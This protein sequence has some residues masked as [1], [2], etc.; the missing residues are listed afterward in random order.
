MYRS[1]IF[2][3]SISAQKV[4]SLKDLKKEILS[5]KTLKNDLRYSFGIISDERRPIFLM[6]LGQE[7]LCRLFR[8]ATDVNKSIEFLNDSYVAEN[9]NG[10]RGTLTRIFTWKSLGV[11]YFSTEHVKNGN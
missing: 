10:I 7:N 6:H 11:G 3:K 2:F 4:S 1:F 5:G 9:K 8:S